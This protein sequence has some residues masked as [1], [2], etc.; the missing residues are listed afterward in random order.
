MSRSRPSPSSSDSAPV[1][2]FAS[3]QTRFLLCLAATLALA[4]VFVNVPMGDLAPRIGWRAGQQ[5]DPITIA[6]LQES[7]APENDSREAPERPSDA[8]PIP[9]RRRDGRPRRIL[10]SARSNH[11]SHDHPQPGSPT[12][13]CRGEGSAVHAR[14]LSQRGRTTRNRR[15]RP[16]GVHRQHHGT[17]NA[18]SRRAVRASPL[19]QCRRPCAPVRAICSRETQRRSR[20]RSHAPPRPLHPDHAV[21]LR[22]DPDRRCIGEATIASKQRRLV[23]AHSGCRP[24]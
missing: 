16:A 13:N 23:I 5:Y 7:T 3:Y 21:V 11:C 18:H 8:A 22:L 15:P 14:P 10:R 12:R 9:T 20:S 17:A 6:D 1:R 24:V 4:L 19:R 2:L